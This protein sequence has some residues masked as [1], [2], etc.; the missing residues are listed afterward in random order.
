MSSGFITEAEVAERKRIRQ[1]EWDKVRT[2]D[3][4]SGKKKNYWLLFV[5]YIDNNNI[6][7]NY[8]LIIN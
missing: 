4:P 1:E 2:A 3:Q 8:K 6:T 5:L 7:I